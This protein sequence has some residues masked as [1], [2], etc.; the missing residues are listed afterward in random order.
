[1]P[2]DDVS[3]PLWTRWHVRDWLLDLGLGHLLPTADR[4]HMTGQKLVTVFHPDD[5]IQF[6]F[7]V[8]ARGLAFVGNR[9]CTKWVGGRKSG[10][11]IAI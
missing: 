7:E 2:Y 6:G 5:L 9:N 3:V 8:R 1:M 11:C 10:L 4:A